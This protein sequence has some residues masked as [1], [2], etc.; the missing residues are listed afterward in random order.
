MAR[1]PRP[2]RG[3]PRPDGAE[4]L[5]LVAE[6]NKQA[7]AYGAILLIIGIVQL[8][9]GV[10]VLAHRSWGR[11][12]AIVLGLLGTIWGIGLLLTSVRFDIGDMSVQGALAGEESAVAMATIVLVCYLLVFL[13]M[14]VGRRHFRRRGV[15]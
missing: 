6:F 9:G 7:T 12:F 14:F 5:D 15:S 1:Q 11:A 2:G 4:A 3:R 8:I 10:G 13:A